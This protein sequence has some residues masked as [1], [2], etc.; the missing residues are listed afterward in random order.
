VCFLHCRAN[1][2]EI[3]FNYLLKLFIIVSSNVKPLPE[4]HIF[5]I[6]ISHHVA[7]DLSPHLSSRTSYFYTS[8]AVRHWRPARPW[9]RGRRRNESRRLI[10]SLVSVRRRVPELLIIFPSCTALFANKADRWPPGVIAGD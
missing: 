7:W 5:N 4:V 10:K 1:G 3:D 6:P 9:I 2:E 8:T